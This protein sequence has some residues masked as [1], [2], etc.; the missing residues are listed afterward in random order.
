MPFELPVLTMA[1]QVYRH[2]LIPRSH[3]SFRVVEFCLV[4]QDLKASF[5]Q[6][7]HG[8]AGQASNTVY[9]HWSHN[10]IA[11]WQTWSTI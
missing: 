10:V 1:R 8:T 7:P 11:F 4:M 6:S 9:T 3:P 5:A 2:K